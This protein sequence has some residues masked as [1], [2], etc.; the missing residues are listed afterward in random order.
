MEKLALIAIAIASLFSCEAMAQT[1]QFTLP[2]NSTYQG[3][4]NAAPVAGPDRRA[5][6]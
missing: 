4:L 5:H 3:H 1:P 6:V 2:P